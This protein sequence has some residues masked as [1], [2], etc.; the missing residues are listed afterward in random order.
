M[1]IN[2]ECER[3]KSLGYQNIQEVMKYLAIAIKSKHT[4]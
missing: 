1:K 3:Y 4:H 2:Q